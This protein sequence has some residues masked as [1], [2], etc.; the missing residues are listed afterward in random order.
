MYTLRGLAREDAAPDTRH[1]NE[2]PQSENSSYLSLNQERAPLTVTWDGIIAR[3]LGHQHPTR[4]RRFPFGI[5]LKLNSITTATPSGRRRTHPSRSMLARATPA[6]ATPI[7]AAP[8]TRLAETRLRAQ[9]PRH[10]PRDDVLRRLR[11]RWAP[12]PVPVDVQQT[13]SARRATAESPSASVTAPRTRRQSTW[14][15]TRS[16]RRSPRACQKSETTPGRSQDTKHR[17]FQEHRQHLLCDDGVTRDGVARQADPFQDARKQG[18]RSLRRAALH[19][20]PGRMSQASLI[21]SMPSWYTVYSETLTKN[22]P[23]DH[24]NRRTGSRRTS[25]ET[26]ELVCDGADELARDAQPRNRR[27]GSRTIYEALLARRA[28]AESPSAS[29]TACTTT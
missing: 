6:T 22:L 17:V 26:D 10:R 28:T 25:P 11:R 16:R 4:L 9:H 20:E 14:R 23:K 8:T 27:T 5:L 15:W 29:T 19:R 13:L 18:L 7:R 12:E 3:R 2:A 1:T 24:R 21:E